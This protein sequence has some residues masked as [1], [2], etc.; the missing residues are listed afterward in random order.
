MVSRVLH[1]SAP[2]EVCQPQFA[3]LMLVNRFG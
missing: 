2:E 1:P 3:R